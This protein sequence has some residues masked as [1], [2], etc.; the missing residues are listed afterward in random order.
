MTGP[1]EYVLEKPNKFRKTIPRDVKLIAIGSVVVFSSIIFI[2]LWVYCRHKIRQQKVRQII[3][4][5]QKLQELKVKSK[6][7]RLACAK[8][9]EDRKKEAQAKKQKEAEEKRKKEQELL[10]AEAV[11][12]EEAAVPAKR[13]STTTNQ[14]RS[15]QKKKSVL[16]SKSDN[17]EEMEP[18]YVKTKLVDEAKEEAKEDI[19]PKELSVQPNS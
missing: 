2:V 4:E 17:Q 19:A 7:Q 11:K 9:I 8:L 16:K 15:E 18:I 6:Q 1:V 12:K 13:D 10:L 3:A 14:E 5:K